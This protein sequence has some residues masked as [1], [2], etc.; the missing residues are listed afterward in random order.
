M[1]G[2]L[3]SI[4]SIYLSLGLVWAALGEVKVR[5][6]DSSTGRAAEREAM[7]KR[8]LAARDI[9]DKHVLDAMRRV[10][11]HLFIPEDRRD[12]A[13]QDHPVPIG[14]KQTISQPY[15][16]AYMTQALKLQ[17]GDRVL[18][19]GTGSGY[20]AAVLGELAREVYS[21]EILPQLGERSKKLLALMGYRNIQV[22][23]GD[24]YKGWPDKAP[25]DAIIVTAAPP[26][27]PQPLL[28]QLKVGGRMIIPVGEIHQGL[29]LIQRTATGYERRNVLPVRF[30]PMTGEAQKKSSRD[31]P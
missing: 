31:K 21:I 5:N 28:D 7:V 12:Q 26:K 17:P 3:K 25:F 1:K 15:I 9:R 27:V 10:P 23:I 8:Q 13:Y 16:V 30:V 18:E 20:Q 2:I 6:A 24:G 14:L 22:R 11:R 19:I 4:A 29:I